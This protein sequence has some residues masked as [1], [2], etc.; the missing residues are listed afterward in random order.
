ML[1]DVQIQSIL[2][3][4][5]QLQSHCREIFELLRVVEEKCGVVDLYFDTGFRGRLKSEICIEFVRQSVGTVQCEHPSLHYDTVA[6]NPSV[7]DVERYW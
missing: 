6:W 1:D 2:F 3:P 5:L 7:R 4:L